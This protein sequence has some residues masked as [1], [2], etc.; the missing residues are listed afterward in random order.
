MSERTH[1]ELITALKILDLTIT[2]WAS[3]LKKPGGE[4]GISRTAVTQVAK[5]I[6]DTQWIKDEIKAVIS[7]AKS[8]NPEYFETE[9][10]FLLSKSA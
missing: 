3:G 6:D 10:Q 9:T 2:G 4:V 1:I 8:K 7:K 5:G